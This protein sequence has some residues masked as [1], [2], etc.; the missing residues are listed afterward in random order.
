MN[1]GGVLQEMAQFLGMDDDLGTVQATRELL[2]GFAALLNEDLPEVG[3]FHAAV[4]YREVDGQTLALDVIVPKGKGPFPVLVYFHGGAWVWGSPA[5]HRKLTFRLAEQGFLTLSVDYRL[6]PEHPF[7]AGFNDCVHAVHFAAHNAGHWGGDPERLVLAGDSAGGNLAAAAAIELAHAVGAPSVRA[8]A[9]LYGVFDFSGP[10]PM[11][12]DITGLLTDAY[13]GGEHSLIKDPRVSPILKA[14]D[15][16][17][18]HIAV[19]SAD[20]LIEDAEALRAAL[21]HAGKRHDY[22]VYED[23]PH[24]FMQMEFL[25]AAQTAIRRMCRF[26]R[27]AVAA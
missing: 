13:L 16:P 6:A 25:P 15:L 4:P 20:P 19:G 18:A 7:P 2:D 1:L 10:D 27:H 5:T 11:A 21:A 9:L 24:A 17:P 3:E 26:L 14:A 12:D 8:V 23:M 22:Q